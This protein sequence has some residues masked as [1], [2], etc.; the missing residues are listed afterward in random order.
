MVCIYGLGNH[1]A[2]RPGWEWMSDFCAS[3]ET[4][5][6]IAKSLKSKKKVKFQFGVQIPNSPRHGLTLDEENGDNLWKEA[7][8]KEIQQINDFKTFRVLPDDA[9]M[10]LGYKRIPYHIVYACK[11]DLRRK[12]RLVAGGHRT[13][14]LKEDI[15]S[16]VVSIEAVRLGYMLAQLNNL[17]V[18]A[19]DVETH[20]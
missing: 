7:T 10:P 4:F 6:N 20:F 17:L 8:D 15:Y 9:P 3:H 16:G 19:G 14:P 2:Q 12:A 5:V 1:L 13:E 11:F 18:C